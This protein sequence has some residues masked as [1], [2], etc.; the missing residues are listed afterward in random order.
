MDF[1]V[2]AV[3]IKVMA[4]S[5]SSSSNTDGKPIEPPAKVPRLAATGAK[6]AAGA[7]P[8]SPG[9]AAVPTKPK[10]PLRWH[11]A[12]TCCQCWS[13]EGS[14]KRF[15]HKSERAH[16]IWQ[17][18]RLMAA[19]LD[20]EDGFIWECTPCYPFHEKLIVPLSETHEIRRVILGP[21][22]LG[23]PSNR[24]RSYAIGIH[25]KPLFWAGP[26][27]GD[28][29]LASEALFARKV[30]TDGAVLMHASN[31]EAAI[32]AIQGLRKLSHCVGGG[33]V[34][35]PGC[36]GASIRAFL[37]PCGAWGD[38]ERLTRR[39]NLGLVAEQVRQA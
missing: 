29:Q 2:C 32:L 6:G 35:C 19:R 22:L 27:Q 1:T 18:Q 8:S 21:T 13:T 17:T 34:R 15:A 26:G 31:T 23:Y 39:R 10:K 4:H 3:H 20:L 37:W 9:A 24:V 16:A 14:R 28:A 36:P 12:G 33:D 25:M 5:G 11:F 30:M 38:L 7:K